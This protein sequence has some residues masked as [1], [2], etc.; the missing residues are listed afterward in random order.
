[1]RVIQRWAIQ[2]HQHLLYW[3]YIIIFN[4]SDSMGVNNSTVW[5]LNFIN[6]KLYSQWSHPILSQIQFEKKYLFP[7]STLQ[8]DLQQDQ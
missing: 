1:M 8:I 7:C 6:T 5:Q 4:I 2:V 3:R